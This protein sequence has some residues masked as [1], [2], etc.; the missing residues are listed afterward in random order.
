MGFFLLR[1][2]V[3]TPQT[4]AWKVPLFPEDQR[5]ILQEPGPRDGHHPLLYA[6]RPVG[7]L[8]LDHGRR[9]TPSGTHEFPKRTFESW[10]LPDPAQEAR[11]AQRRGCGRARRGRQPCCAELYS[12]NHISPQITSP[13]SLKPLTPGY[14]HTTP[15]DNQ[16]ISKRDAQGRTFAPRT[17][18]APAPASPQPGGAGRASASEPEVLRSRT[19]ARP[20]FPG[21]G[22]ARR[23]RGAAGA[24]VPSRGGSRGRRPGRAAHRGLL[25][26]RRPGPGRTAGR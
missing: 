14:C 24:E 8:S 10:R 16:V 18:V 19:R 9:E 25:V 17:R 12:P 4:L 23:G 11:A 3:L 21:A 2:C 15:C 5:K 26:S 20:P 6:R 1:F 7:D 22:G 13:S